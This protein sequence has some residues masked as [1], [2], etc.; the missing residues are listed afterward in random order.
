MSVTEEDILSFDVYGL[1]KQVKAI[2]DKNNAVLDATGGR[3]NIF[4]ILG[5]KQHETTHSKI[6][7]SFLNPKGTHGMKERFLELFLEECFSGEDLCEF[8]FECKNAVVKTESYAPTEGT[9]GRIDILITSGAKR[10]VIEN[11]L[12]TG[13]QKG[14]LKRYAHWSQKNSADFKILYL[15]KDGHEASEQSGDGIDYKTISYKEEILNWLEKC[16]SESSKL[17]LVRET[18]VQYANLIRNYTGESMSAK[19]TNEIINTIANE[20]NIRIAQ[21]I[22]KNYRKAKIQIAQELLYDFGEMERILRKVFGLG[23]KRSEK[24]KI[25]SKDFIVRFDIEGIDDVRI[26]ILFGDTATEKEELKRL[27][28]NLEFKG[29]KNSTGE[30]K[31]ATIEK[32]RTLLADIPHQVNPTEYS[33]WRMQFEPWETCKKGILNCFEQML[34]CLK[35]R[36][37][38]KQI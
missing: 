33:A 36:S 35:I 5:V 31:S 34:N 29:G 30:E 20:E 15:T 16:C 1:I 25:G 38:E 14:Q 28:I 24:G 23:Y 32:Y 11:K 4:Q 19:A 22:V 10:I 37:L 7:A 2:K 26:A 18:L 13:D 8:N 9:Q 12:L 3:F 21:L 17:P 27:K 6:I